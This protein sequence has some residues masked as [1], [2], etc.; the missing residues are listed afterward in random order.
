VTLR[1]LGIALAV[2]IGLG[3]AGLVCQR[4][5]E[6]GRYA[7]SYST[8]GAGP[9]GT[10]GLYLLAEEL[11]A[12]PVRW[13]EDLARL[14]ERGMLVALG[15]CEA[16]QLRELSRYERRILIEWVEGG[17]VLV[18]AGAHTYLDPDLGVW[19]DRPETECDPTA[20]LLGILTRDQRAGD[21]GE[22]LDQVPDDF[23]EDPGETFD[24]LASEDEPRP[25]EWA[26]PVPGGL[27]EGLGPIGLRQPATLV[28]GDG[29]IF[30]PFLGFDD[31]L[32]GVVAD[33]GEGHVVVL[34]SA[35]LFQNRDLEE[36]DG[37]ALFA[38]LVREH[39][40]AGPVIFDEYHLGV[41][42]R[43]STARYLRQ[44]GG[45]PVAIQLVVLVLLLLWR[46]GARFGATREDPPPPPGGTA[47]YVAAIGTLYRRSADPPGAIGIL[48]RHALGR[49]AERHRLPHSDPTALEKALEERR[50]HD[51]A[52]AVR[53]IAVTGRGPLVRSRDLVGLARELDH[54]VTQATQGT[55]EG[56]R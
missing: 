48:V 7:A 37:G 10:R 17:G 13:A 49:V 55:A 35:S 4:V 24:E 50:H 51:A 15:G 54:L 25:I 21:D 38:R 40:P 46:A 26:E 23:Q 19:L 27:L 56:R 42:E 3:A 5:A 36:A 30:R 1:R 34:A 11:G 9:G 22:E 43:R 16:R 18:V 29:T 2:I 14:P 44:V 20:G 6:R 41:G 47:S 39:A 32:A 53:R 33:R 45:G 8:Y 52:A 31:E 12:E 28:L